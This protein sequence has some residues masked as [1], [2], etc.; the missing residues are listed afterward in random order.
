MEALGIEA[1][2]QDYADHA[3]H[4]SDPA[5]DVLRN[6]TDHAAT[7]TA[8]Q[9]E[10]T[11]STHQI[12]ALQANGDEAQLGTAQTLALPN[13]PASQ[14]FYVDATNGS[15]DNSGN[16]PSQAWKSLSKV[17]STAFA[18]GSQILFERGETW[19]DSLMVSSSGTSDRSIAYGAYGAGNAPVIDASDADCAVSLNSQDNVTFDHLTITGSSDVG[20]LLNGGA[21][22]VKVTSTTVSG[23]YGSGIAI[24]GTSDNLLIDN[25]MVDGNGAYGIVHYNADNTNQRII[26]S[27]ITGNGWRSDGMYSGWNGLI[28]SGEIAGNTIHDN[29]VGGG[30]G[31][32]RSHGLYHDDGQVGS[33]LKIHHNTVYGQENGG[34]IIAKSSTD[35]Y[36]N[37][38]YKNSV[39]LSLGQNADNSIT[40]NIHGNE[41]FGNLNGGVVEHSK[42]SG[43]ISLN[44]TGNTF[45]DNNGNAPVA[46]A[47]TIAENISNNTVYTETKAIPAA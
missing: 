16:D 28:K 37:M 40:Y 25:V 33:T 29:G 20:L 35:L 8:G 38:M 32:G 30:G 11:L 4:V 3:S 42:G 44:M 14:V 19:H 9:S 41:I 43:S 23:N 12:Q 5:A 31:G 26:N 34:G 2:H 45:Y 22:N 27:E 24:G 15:D 13:A 1:H 39:G 10:T 21:E 47:D 6:S 46:I 17:N 7:S 36:N 18:P